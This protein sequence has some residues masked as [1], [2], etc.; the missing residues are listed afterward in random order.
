MA[1]LPRDPS[2]KLPPGSIHTSVES[3]CRE[4]LYCESKGVKLRMAHRCA[5]WDGWEEGLVESIL[6]PEALEDEWFKIDPRSTSVTN[7]GGCDSGPGSPFLLGGET[8]TS[9]IGGNSNDKRKTDRECRR[10][11]SNS[12]SSRSRRSSISLR[13][14]KVSSK[15]PLVEEQKKEQMLMTTGDICGGRGGELGRRL[16]AWLSVDRNDVSGGHG[17]GGHG[18]DTTGRGRSIRVTD[19][20][21][22]KE[23]WLEGQRT[24][25]S[26]C[27]L[28]S[29]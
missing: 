29:P 7:A 11:A 6:G 12:N 23:R 10:R 4:W 28:A 13:G 26:I 1:E 24:V 27:D 8:L 20:V 19:A 21:F 25:A 16:E 5:E 9:A 18:S 14:G 2:V 17:G 3:L 22:N 15:L